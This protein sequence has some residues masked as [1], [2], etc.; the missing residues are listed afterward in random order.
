MII[1]IQLVDSRIRSSVAEFILRELDSLEK[2]TKEC[3]E[4]EFNEMAQTASNGEGFFHSC[5]ST[6]NRGFKLEKQLRMFSRLRRSAGNCEFFGKIIE[7][8]NH[9]QIV[10][11]ILDE[12][13]ESLLTETKTELRKEQSVIFQA[14]VEVVYGLNKLLSREL[15]RLQ[16]EI[17]D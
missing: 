16:A 4:I 10:G 12:L 9:I 6:V 14:E 1:P 13:S 15:Y 2:T 8:K 5:E 3:F 17:A 7:D 11:K